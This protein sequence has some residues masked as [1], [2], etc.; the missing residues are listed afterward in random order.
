[1]TIPHSA[2]YCFILGQI[3]VFS[4]EIL[5]SSLSMF[6]LVIV[7]ANVD[8][9]EVNCSGCGPMDFLTTT[10]VVVADS[11]MD[12][13]FR[14]T[15][16]LD[17]SSFSFFL[18]SDF[19]SSSTTAGLLLLFPLSSVFFFV[20]SIKDGIKGRERGRSRLVSEKVSKNDDIERH[21]AVQHAP[22]RFS[23]EYW[24]EFQLL[25]HQYQYQHQ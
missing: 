13:R 8:A 14:L 15:S 9:T 21:G 18:S 22:L 3:F 25:V 5:S 1:M 4:Y 19:S 10:L 7:D 11:P 2:K 24:R 23:E 12:F 20:S 17:S 16:S 6:F